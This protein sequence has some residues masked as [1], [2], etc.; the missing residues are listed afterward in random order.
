MA[1]WK[2]EVR[3]QIGSGN[4][5]KYQAPDRSQVVFCYQIPAKRTD[6]SGFSIFINICVCLSVS[7]PSPYQTKNVKDLKSVSAVTRKFHSHIDIV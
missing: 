6:A 2:I 3:G 4:F 7:A 1:E 5:I